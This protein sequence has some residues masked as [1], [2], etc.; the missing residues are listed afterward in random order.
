[1]NAYQSNIREL[2][3]NIEAEQIVLGAMLINN[4]AYDEVRGYLQP[5]HFYDALHAIVFSA[6]ATLIKDGKPANPVTIRGDIPTDA[7]IGGRPAFEYVV[8]LTS[9]ALAY[10]GVGAYGRLVYDRAF[11]RT[12]IGNLMTGL[13]LAYDQSND[14]GFASVSSHIRSGIDNLM[15]ESVMGDETA[16]SLSDAMEQALTSIDNAYH[17]KKPG[18]IMTGIDAVDQLTGPWE[19]GQQIIIGGG[20]KQGKTSLASQCAMGLATNGPVYIYSGEMSLKQVA[21]RELARR[22]GIPVWCQKEGRVSK[23][24]LER[25]HQVRFEIKRLPIF[26]EKKRLTLEQIHEAMRTMKRDH[27]LASCMIDHI[28]LL[29]WKGVMANKEPAAQAVVA[30]RELKAIYE[31]LAI[32][33]MSLSQ[34]KKNTFVANGYGTRPK[35]FSEKMREAIYR[36]PTYQDLMGAVENDADHVLIPF[37]ARP[38]LASMEPEE[39]TEDHGLWQLRMEEHKEKAEIILALSREQ[40]FPQRREVAWHG[41]TTSFGP[42][43]VGRQESLLGDNY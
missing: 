5:E 11:K 18:G 12:L 40:H 37:N 38:I 34:L 8:S 25:L 6:C 22:T 35:S 13:D 28:G 17:F 41:E 20:T 10:S 29:A 3:H 9:E 33:G 24:D 21:M 7:K 15:A 36:R 31:D 39:G 27:G 1:V 4:G 23:Q 30:T 14:A 19:P 42:A 43:F 32:P 2:P 26:I 16:V